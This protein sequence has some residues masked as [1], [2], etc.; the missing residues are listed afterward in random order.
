MASL[1]DYC[2][3]GSDVWMARTLLI[4]FEIIESHVPD[5]VM[6]QLG[7]QQG[8]PPLH[9]VYDS[10]EAF[11]DCHSHTRSGKPGVDWG[12]THRNSIRI[13]DDRRS[14]LAEGVPRHTPTGLD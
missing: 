3:A 13:W 4:S 7:Y 9:T 1:P 2:V 14:Q 11:L 5:R 10:R 6:R 12:V 8:I